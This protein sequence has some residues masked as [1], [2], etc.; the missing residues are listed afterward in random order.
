MASASGPVQLFKSS[1]TNA[2]TLTGQ[3]GSLITL[4]NQCLVSGYAT[5][6]V[7]SLTL[8]GTTATATIA[9]TATMVTGQYFTIAGAAQ[10]QYNGSQQ[11]TVISATQ[12]TYQVSGSPVTPATGTI[13]Y[14]KSP[15]GWTKPF[16][17]GTN[18]QTYR[19]ADS[20]SN[21]FYLQV[22]DNG[23]TAGGAREAQVYAAEVMTADQTVSSGRFPTAVQMASGACWFKS[24]SADSVVRPWTLIGDSRTFYLFTNS[25]VTNNQGRGYGFGYF[26]SYKSGDGYN[27]FISG[28]SVFNGTSSLNNLGFFTNLGLG[29]GNGANLYASSFAR[30]YTQ[31]GAAI[32]FACIGNGVPGAAGAP[33]N[34]HVTLPNG[35]DTGVYFLPVTCW[36][37]V[38]SNHL[39]G[40]LPGL[41][42]P[43]FNTWNS[44]TYWDQVT[45]TYPSTITMVATEVSNSNGSGS[46]NTYYGHLFTDI[47]GP[48]N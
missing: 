43:M 6:S 45:I 29:G 37:N 34:P 33:G 26:I 31:T 11:I 28:D 12:F 32:S 44:F 2:P 20:T 22:I 3:V 25:N 38:G 17:A 8:V 1:D 16:S 35:P 36:E 47:W 40:R 15:L 39:R 14:A 5:A 48:W 10:S 23:A 24:T 46:T 7:S 19:S 18:S 13:T 42:A 41:Y 21:Q 27:T 30:S 9:S 4:L